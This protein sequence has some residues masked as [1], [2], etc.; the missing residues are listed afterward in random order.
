M[1]DTVLL[2][3]VK[4]MYPYAVSV[5]RILHAHPELSGHERRTASFIAAETRKL[6]LK[7]D[8]YLDKTAV[9]CHIKNGHGKTVVLRA[10]IDALPIEEKTGL[11][12]SSRIAGIMHACGH[13][14]HAA[15]LLGAAKFL[16]RLRDRWQGTVVLLFQ[17][18]EEM[19]PG[20]AMGLIRAG[21]F[22]ARTTGVFGLHVNPEHKTGTIGIRQGNDFAGVLNFAVRVHG[23]GGHAAAPQATENPITCAAHMID[24]LASLAGQAMRKGAIIA[25]GSFNAGSRSNIIPDRAD[26]FGTIRF[27]SKP[28]GNMIRKEVAHLIQGSARLHRVSAS[29]AFNVSYPPN[30]NDPSLTGKMEKR[31]RIL[32][33]PQKVVVRREPVF[34]AEDFAYFQQ[35][36]PGVYVHL[37]VTPLRSIKPPVSLHNA[38][39]SPDEKAI[40]TG[41]LAHVAF[42]ETVCGSSKWI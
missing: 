11:P 33:G 26:F 37:G 16:I 22:P 41:M 25:V 18:S 15:I 24:R 1:H 5:R 7:P 40:T 21:A 27:H 38:H 34:F 39:F 31:L 23:R 36:A 6:G 30:W 42:V 32:L 9:V 20:G 4:E 19:E 2:Q 13:D 17:P 29:V 3:T 14:M 28:V 10:D 35:K 12:F 8:Y